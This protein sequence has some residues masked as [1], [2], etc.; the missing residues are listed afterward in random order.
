M[1][2]LFNIAYSTTLRNKHIEGDNIYSRC[3]YEGIDWRIDRIPKNA[4]KNKKPLAFGESP[5]THPFLLD[6]RIKNDAYLIPVVDTTWMGLLDV[7][8]HFYSQAYVTSGYQHCGVRFLGLK[9]QE[10]IYIWSAIIGGST[11]ASYT[12]LGSQKCY[13][14]HGKSFSL[15]QVPKEEYTKTKLF[16]NIPWYIHHNPDDLNPQSPEKLE[17]QAIDYLKELE[18]KPLLSHPILLLFS[19]EEGEINNDSQLE[20]ILPVIYTTPIN[21]IRAVYSF[22]ACLFKDQIFNV[23]GRVFTFNGIIC[24]EHEYIWNVLFDN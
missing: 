15:F 10:H 22:F 7:I 23:Y 3:M 5:I 18:D 4:T 13:N 11:H 16:T 17:R 21:I 24:E 2:P 12:K 1:D 9:C 8:Y 6:L 19:F 14:Q 20:Y